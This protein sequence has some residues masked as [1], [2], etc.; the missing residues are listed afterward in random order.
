MK[1][2]KRLDKILALKAKSK[3]VPLPASSTLKEHRTKLAQQV[4]LEEKINEQGELVFQRSV[5]LDSW[6]S[7]EDES[8]RGEEDD[9]GSFY[10]EP[11]VPGT[12]ISGSVSPTSIASQRGY[13]PMPFRFD[14]GNSTFG[15][16]CF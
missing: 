8:E 15:T 14:R 2:S 7:E 4:L 9:Y 13:Y 6:D 3:P 1:V 11:N 12:S 5:S 16:I 10:E